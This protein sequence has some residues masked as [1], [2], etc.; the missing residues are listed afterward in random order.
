MTA[1]I[2]EKSL[3][4]TLAE[5]IIDLAKELSKDPQALA[6]LHLFRT[7]A[8]YKM[9]YGTGKTLTDNLVKTLKTTPFSHC[10]KQQHGLCFVSHL[11]LLYY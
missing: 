11:L 8:S 6:K 9:V 2:T 5:P 3:Y 10:S 4:F 1:F 7:T